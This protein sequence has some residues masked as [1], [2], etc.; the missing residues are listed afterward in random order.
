M[1]KLGKNESF[2]EQ[3]I[4]YKKQVSAQEWTFALQL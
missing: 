2:F 4:H 3:E 1:I